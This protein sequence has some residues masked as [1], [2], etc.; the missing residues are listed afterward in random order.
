MTKKTQ[1]TRNKRPSPVSFKFDEKVDFALGFAARKSGKT[2][3]QILEDSLMAAI[4]D[5]G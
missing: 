4:K 5:T 2:K 3:T 1:P